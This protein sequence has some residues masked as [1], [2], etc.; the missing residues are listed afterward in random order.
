MLTAVE[1]S[2]THSLRLTLARQLAEV[3]LRGVSGNEWAAPANKTSD[4]P[5]KSKKYTGINQVCFVFNNFYLFLFI[6]LMVP[7]L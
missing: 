2:G 4:G 6:S 1:S 5:W 3:L 7:I